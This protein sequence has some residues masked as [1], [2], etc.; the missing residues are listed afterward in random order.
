MHFFHKSI[1]NTKIVLRKISFA[2]TTV[3]TTPE[4]YLLIQ[5]E[6][7]LSCSMKVDGF[8]V[9]CLEIIIRLLQK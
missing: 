2:I 3:L 1:Y 8:S 5:I 9:L 7:F 4:L 6:R